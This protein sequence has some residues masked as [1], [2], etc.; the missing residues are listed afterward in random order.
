VNLYARYRPKALADIVGNAD[1]KATLPAMLM[2]EHPPH[3]FLLTGPSGCGKTTVARIAAAELGVVPDNNRDWDY[4]EINAA[5]F[6]GIDAVRE[7]RRAMQ[8]GHRRVFVL[9]ECHMLTNEAQHALLKLLEEPGNAFFFLATTD[10]DKL[11]PMLRGRCIE[12]AVKPIIVPQMVRLLGKISSKEC[13]QDP[14]K[15]LPSLQVL[16][17]IARKHVP[18]AVVQ[19]S[20]GG[21]Y[22]R[23]ALQLLEQVL[24]MPD[25]AAQMRIIRNGSG[26]ETRHR[27]RQPGRPAAARPKRRSTRRRSS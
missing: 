19:D 20:G 2:Q 12:L 15:V 23:F 1:L 26:H 18:K 7:I 14:Q 8:Y 16:N 25:E 11:I 21:C 10:P 9:D 5:D 24:A 27:D 13:Q 6:R 3:A 17:A 4:W 22:P